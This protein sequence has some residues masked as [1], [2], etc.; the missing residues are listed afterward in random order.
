MCDASWFHYNL[1][2]A[3]VG[4][5]LE[6]RSLILIPLSNNLAAVPVIVLL[7]QIIVV[8]FL[9]KLNYLCLTMIALLGN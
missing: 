6:W 7:C 1:K 2:R 3:D 8:S 9:A 5:G 4:G